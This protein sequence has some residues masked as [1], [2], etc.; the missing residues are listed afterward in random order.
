MTNP[1]LGIAEEARI[2]TNKQL[3][4]RL[5]SFTRMTAAEINRLAPRKRD[6][7]EFAR[8]MEVVS[9]ETSE[10]EKIAYLREN[11]ASIGKVLVNVLK[12]AV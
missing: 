10:E 7:E 5:S 2:L 4:D 12:M 9:G 11:I 8:L 3:S 6:K 1:Y